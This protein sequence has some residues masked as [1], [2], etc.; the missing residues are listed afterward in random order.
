MI[1][2]AEQLLTEEVLLKKPKDHFGEDQKIYGSIDPRSDKVIDHKYWE[3]ILWNAWHFV[4][5]FYHDLHG[6]R[7]GGAELT[8]TKDSFR[9]LPGEWTTKEW[10]E[11]KLQYLAPIKDDLVRLLRLTRFG[12]VTEETLPEG[13]FDEKKEAT[14]PEGK[15]KRMFG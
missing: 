4:K 8:L 2:G 10:D 6:I 15:Q 12:K 13:V 9:L 14:K 1:S 11:I 5:P 7:C 3:D